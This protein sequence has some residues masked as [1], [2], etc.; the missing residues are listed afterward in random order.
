MRQY[1]PDGVVTIPENANRVFKGIIYDV[2]HWDQAQF[3]GS[4]KTF[5]ML[6]RP[7]TVQVIPIKDGRVVY[8]EEEQPGHKPFVSLP[9]GRH[10][11]EN[12]SELQAAQR[13][14]LEETGMKFKSWKLVAVNQLHTKLDWLIY[15]FVAYDFESQVAA[16]ND[17][18]EK[19]KVL[20]AT[21]DEIKEMALS[22]DKRIFPK[23]VFEAASSTEEIIN[24]PSLH[25]Y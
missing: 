1:I 10:D 7:D 9:G 23:E 24:L 4:T 14:L 15:H 22:Q 21:L 13:E 3:D 8:I 16:Q 12:E 2:Y 17:S 20:S 18:G 25:K 19:I 6:K 11:I 5:E